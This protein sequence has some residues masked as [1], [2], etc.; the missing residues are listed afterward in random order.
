MSG[1]VNGMAN[2]D[3]MRMGQVDGPCRWPIND[4]EKD[5]WWANMALHSQWRVRLC[6]A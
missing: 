1:A 2:G 5:L 6:D 4:F 3:D